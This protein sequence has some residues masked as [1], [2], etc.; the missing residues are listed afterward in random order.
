MA[1]VAEKEIQDE[2]E[3]FFD[4][5]N[6]DPA[7]FEKRR[8]WWGKNGS[9]WDLVSEIEAQGVYAGSKSIY[10]SQY[11]PLSMLVHGTPFALRYYVFQGKDSALVDWKASMPDPSRLN[12]PRQHSHRLLPGC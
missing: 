10:R 6:L 8:N 3:S 5:E 7:T 11:G 1:E 2:I 9:I 4:Q 12:L